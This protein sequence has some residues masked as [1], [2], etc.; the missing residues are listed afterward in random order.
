MFLFARPAVQYK[1]ENLIIILSKV[2]WVESRV[3]LHKQT[4]RDRKPTKNL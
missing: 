1:A 4:E 2:K 3:K